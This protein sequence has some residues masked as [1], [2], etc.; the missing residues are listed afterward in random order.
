M[1]QDTASIRVREAQARDGTLQNV[2]LGRQA[3]RSGMTF[4]DRAVV[5]ALGRRYSRVTGSSEGSRWSLRSSEGKCHSQALQP[6]AVAL[7][8]W[9][10]GR[11]GA[12]LKVTL[13]PVRP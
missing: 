8:P 11:A 2:A 10:R 9:K 3:G 7:V 5:A 1:Q 13:L 4:G 12:A 6:P